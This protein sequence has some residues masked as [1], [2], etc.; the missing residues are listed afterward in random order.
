MKY[1]ILLLL[2]LPLKAQFF[3]IPANISQTG[4]VISAS[5]DATGY[6]ATLKFR[7]MVT[8]GTI[9]NLGSFTNYMSTNCLI[10]F[11]VKSMG[12]D[13]SGTAIT[14]QRQ[15]VATTNLWFP[16]PS[17]AIV[18]SQDS[19]GDVFLNFALSQ[20]IYQ[21][22]SNI[23]F[24]A[25]KN[26]YGTNSVNSVMSY[27]NVVNN[28]TLAY[29]AVL[30][31]WTIDP[32]RLE[33]NS[34]MTARFMAGHMYA[35]HSNE[36]AAVKF[37]TTDGTVTVTTWATNMTVDS[38]ASRFQTCAVYQ[39]SI[40]LASLTQGISITNNATVYPFIGDSGAILDTSTGA[41][42]PSPLVGP[43][44]VVNDRAGTYGITCARAQAITGIDLTGVA[45][46]ISTFNPI[47][48]L[49]C[50]NLG[51]ALN[52]IRAYNSANHSRNNSGGGIVFLDD[53]AYDKNG[54]N[55]PTYST[56][57]CWAIV[58][59][60]VNSSARSAV[61]ISSSSGNGLLNIGRLKF[62]DVTIDVT[63]AS[64]FNQ[65][66]QL[67]FE[68]CT[69]NTSGSIIANASS[70][71][72]WY[73]LNCEVP[74]LGQG[75]NA[76]STDNCPLAKLIGCDIS[77]YNGAGIQ[78]TAIGN[79]KAGAL[80]QCSIFAGVAAGS[81][82]PQAQGRIIYGNRLLNLNCGGAAVIQMSPT[83]TNSVG[84]F[85]ALN[86]IENASSTTGAGQPMESIGADGSSS[87]TAIL[88]NFI[89][90][91]NTFVGAR[92]NGP[93]NDNAAGH[94]ARTLC[95][96]MNDVVWYYAIKEATFAATTA[97]TN[98]WEETYGCDYSGNV[99]GNDSNLWGLRFPGLSSFS[100]QW[101]ANNFQ[102]Y[103]NFTDYQAWTGTGG[104]GAGGGTYTTSSGS[105]ARNLPI[106]APLPFDLLGVPFGDP[107][108]SAGAYSY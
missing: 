57:D 29:P 102:T 52:K 25:Y 58:T 108:R 37:T 89:S 12:Y 46:D 104:N 42:Q 75:L 33:T 7:K 96:R 45:T 72:A 38:F 22:D 70:V 90:H 71:S 4:Q 31:N 9:V 2:C 32:Y 50:L 74:A 10:G 86:V 101:N 85:V 93:Y 8:N 30:G 73:L 16:Y 106:T 28:S 56:S 60:S 48:T 17:Q 51:A 5:I 63:T 65:I 76:A 88:K 67:A 54:T 94:P 27:G 59:R 18:Y 81:K 83:A 69:I 64:T 68:N 40:S 87:S 26:V 99:L 39:A 6:F 24:C 95:Q 62:V 43:T 3:S 92:S 14:R 105:P 82:A 98:N 15:L 55:Q 1:L 36:V 13:S 107:A 91:Q 41:A 79:Y 61:T 66:P 47:T 35:Q 100:L 20:R 21:K 53:G 19:S 11:N 84:D 78:Y 103:M 80:S 34:T 44:Y 97:N 77:G 23:T 49:P